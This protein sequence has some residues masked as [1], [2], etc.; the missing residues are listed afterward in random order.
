LNQSGSRA[1]QELPPLP[2][3]SLAPSLSPSPAE[4][5]EPV[6]NLVNGGPDHTIAPRDI[7]L[8]LNERNIISGKRQRTQ[9]TR[10]ADAAVSRPAKRG[11]CASARE[12]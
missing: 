2:T 10:A 3:P 4:L 1:S 9:S 12:A 11:L 6:N 5:E 8:D 7:D